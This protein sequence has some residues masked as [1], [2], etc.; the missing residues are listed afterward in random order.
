MLNPEEIKAKLI[1]SKS[2]Q[3]AVA[4]K[5]GIS[6]SQMSSIISFGPLVA[7][8]LVKEIGENPFQ[9]T[10]AELIKHSKKPKR[11]YTKRKATK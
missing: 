11:K 10:D 4:E 2:T 7:A 5:I 9:M 3:S 8:Q 1:L 6:R